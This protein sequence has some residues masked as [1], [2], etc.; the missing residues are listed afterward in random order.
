MLLKYAGDHELKVSIK[1][2]LLLL[3]DEPNRE[4]LTQKQTSFH[5]CKLQ[6]LSDKA[7]GISTNILYNNKT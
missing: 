6:K 4:V 5:I 1:Y 3:D 2:H 7:V